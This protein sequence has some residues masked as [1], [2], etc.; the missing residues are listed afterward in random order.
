MHVHL[1]INQI[2]PDMKKITLLLL[3]VLMLAT[4]SLFAQKQ[5]GYAI[6]FKITITGTDDPNILNNVPESKT[7]FM[8]GNCTKTVVDG[9][10]YSVSNITNGDKKVVDVIFDLTGMGKYVI[11]TTEAEAQ[12]KMENI[13]IDLK[14]TGEHKTIAGYDCEKVIVTSTDLESDEEATTTLYVSKDLNS[15][16]GMHFATYPGLVG[17]PLYMEISQ[18]IQGT[19]ITQIMEATAVTPNKKIKLADFLLPSDG[20][21]VTEEEFA[22]MFGGGGDDDE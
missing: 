19:E 13:K 3:T 6:T 16:P 2:L 17:Y 1:N 18:D 22:K 12:K 10:G 20:K 7:E 4:S 5:T 11:E 9:E 8:L 21:K 15:N 14:Y